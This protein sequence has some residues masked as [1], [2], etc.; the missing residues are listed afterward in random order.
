[1]FRFAVFSYCALIFGVISGGAA[2]VKW[3]GSGRV[4]FV[5]GADFLK[6]A[7]ADDPVSIELSYDNAGQGQVFRQLFD[8]SDQLFWQQEE[9]Y[10]AI[11]VDLRITIGGNTWHGTLASGAEG[12]PYSIEVQDVRVAGDTVD[13]FKV[14]VAEEDGGTFPSF[15]G[16]AALGAN[17]SL[18]VEFRDAS[19]TAGA[20][21]YLHSTDLECV[22]QS[23]TRISEAR[24]SISSGAGQLINFTI[25]PASI[26]TRLVDVEVLDLKKVTYDNEFDEV[27]LTWASTPG[28]FY[29]IEYLADDLCWREKSS[30]FAVSTETTWVVLPF[31]DSELYRVVE[32]E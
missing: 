31:G 7:A 13:F 12:P 26:Q 1:M 16:G 32:E 8:L 30:V 21:D 18:R 25:D 22:S 28:K 23:F 19:T 4:Q 3:T 24:G 5:R 17:P 29:V 27:A 14:T 20:P 2:E 10:A 9:Y 11:D 6:V 15:P